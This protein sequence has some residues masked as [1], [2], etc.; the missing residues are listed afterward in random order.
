MILSILR[1]FLGMC[2]NNFMLIEIIIATAIIGLIS[3]IGVALL[4]NKE[5][6]KTHLTSLISLAAGSLLA[7]SFLDLLP[8]AIEGAEG[9]F[10][11]HLILLVVLFGFLIF[12]LLERIF[13]WHHC[14]CQHHDHLKSRT[15]QHLIFFNLFGDALHNIIDGFLIAGAF[16]LN[17]Q[18]GMAVT[19]AVVLHEI[20]QE[21][22]DFGILIYG[23]LSKVKALFYNFVVALLAVAGAVTFYFFAKEISSLIP[24][25]AAFAAGNFI[26]L[27]AADLIPELHEEENAN[28][29]IIHSL[30]LLTGVAIIYLAQIFLPLI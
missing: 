6:S 21:L 29:V 15:K 25:M 22:S 9:I 3:L 17:F 18:T 26:Y 5:I 16:M 28:Q 11:P 2:Y 19:L 27:A 23:G 14:R 20:P 30:W 1:P 8:E 24:L 7:V 13:H 4:F 12:F 10:E